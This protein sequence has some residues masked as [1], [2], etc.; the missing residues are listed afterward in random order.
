M[1]IRPEFRDLYPPNWREIS[2]RIRFERAEGR[3]EH[4]GRPHLQWVTCMP[5]GRWR[6][7][8]RLR[9]LAGET[10]N[11][12]EFEQVDENAF[13]WR[14]ALGQPIPAPMDQVL[15][16]GRKTRVVLAACHRDHN[17]RNSVDGNLLALCQRC[18]L[19]HD[20]DEHDER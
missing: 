20:R 1:P 6:D 9:P 2:N 5:D 16:L 14:D 10:L 15:R 17:P 8:W 12:L 3:C 13:I 18:H 11:D 7:E 4:C 19:L